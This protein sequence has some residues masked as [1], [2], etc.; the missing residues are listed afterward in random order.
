MQRPDAVAVH[1]PFTDAYYF[2]SNRKS[3]RYGEASHRGLYDGETAIESIFKSPG[4]INFVK[5]LAFQALPY[6]T[7]HFLDSVEHTFLVREPIEVYE[8]LIKLKPDF[9]EDEFGFTALEMMIKKVDQSKRPARFFVDCN[10][11]R[12]A[13]ESVLSRYCQHLKLPFEQRM[14]S[15][16]PGAIREWDSHEEKSQKVWHSALDDSSGILPPKEKA[17]VMLRP[18]H[19]KIIKNAERIYEKIRLG[20][21]DYSH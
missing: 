15:W 9:T 17:R 5:E 20:A 16:K 19:K 6:V 2:G 10:E 14:L 1:E 8:S 13:P 21:Y 4:S 7:P 18:E 12:A 11:F 3:S